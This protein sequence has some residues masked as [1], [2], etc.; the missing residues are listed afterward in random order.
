[1]VDWVSKIFD[2]A[3]LPAKFVAAVC[4]ASGFVVLS[5]ESWLGKIALAQLQ[6]D[7]RTHFGIAFA[8]S[9]AYLVVLLLTWIVHRAQEAKY[10]S[11]RRKA[12]RGEVQFLDQSE[13]AVLREFLLQDRNTLQMPIN[14]PV[15][16]GLL[17][18]GVLEQ[19][20]PLGHSSVIGI[21]MSVRIS[22][23]VRDLVTP[24]FVGWSEGSPTKGQLE[25]DME[26]RPDFFKTH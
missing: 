8:F 7:Y 16:A 18:K 23:K 2:L 26:R 17:S 13:I 19:V 6:V 9:A 22:S 12:V 25:G 4:L 24:Q 5:P 3:K 20:S 15:V 1:M 10:A 11:E 14:E 21:E